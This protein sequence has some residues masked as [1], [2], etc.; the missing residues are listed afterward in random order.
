[1]LRPR[2]LSVAVVEGSSVLRVLQGRQWDAPAGSRWATVVIP[3]TLSRIEIAVAMAELAGVAP[4][5]LLMALLTDGIERD[6]C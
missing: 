4:R 6:M 5:P 2:G 3:P 1:M